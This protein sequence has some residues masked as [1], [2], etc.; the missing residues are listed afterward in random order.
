MCDMLARPEKQ[1]FSTVFET[2][3]LRIGCCS[4]QGWRKTME[5][6]HVAQ[7]NLNGKKTRAFFAVFDGHQSDEAA[8]YCRAHM[9]DEVIKAI[10]NTNGEYKQ[11]FE[12]AFH[13][14]DEQICRRFPSS[15]TAANCVLLMDRKII[16]ANVGDSRAVLFSDGK[17]IP[18]STDHKPTLPDEEAR[19]RRAGAQVE[20]GRV[21]MT[22]A[23]SRAL[24]DVDFKT[25]K[26]LSWKEQAVT[27]LPDVTQYEIQKTAE[28]II[29]G[30]DGVWDVLSNQD[31]CL[32]AHRLLHDNETK[33]SNSVD[34][35]LVCEQI[36][37]ICI[38]QS[39][40]ARVGTD[41]MTIII[42]EFKEP[43]LHQ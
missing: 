6:A 38:A 21:N 28:L 1:K 12:N 25:N 26:A 31:C 4:M 3:H 22:L 27:S 42:V 9:L 10:N 37:D 15:G 19:I 2:T 17:A 34:I 11:S 20:N 33:D 14:I 23:V 24:G 13:A 32:L 41:N 43:F 5:D 29:L 18:L 30:C 7:L 39:N 35:S 36:L 16:C 8:H 40:T